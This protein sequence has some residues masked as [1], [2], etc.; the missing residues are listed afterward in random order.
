MTDKKL[1]CSI[2]PKY[3]S[4][5]AL[6]PE[7]VDTISS[8]FFGRYSV[9]PYKV[10]NASGEKYVIIIKHKNS[11]VVPLGATLLSPS[12]GIFLKVIMRHRVFGFN[13]GR[14]REKL[15]YEKVDNSLC[16]ALPKYLGSCERVKGQSVSLAMIKFPQ[17]REVGFDDLY[18]IIDLITDFHAKY[19]G[20]RE[21][22]REMGLNYYMP[23]DYRQ[24]RGTLG[25]LFNYYYDENVE[26]YGKEFVKV[27][28]DFI[29]HIDEEYAK[30]M[31]YQTLTHNDLTPRNIS[32]DKGIIIYDWELACFQNPEHDL[33]EL[34]FTTVDDNCTSEQIQKVINYFRRQLENKTEKEIS[35]EEFTKRMHFNALEYVVNRLAIYRSYSKKNYSS[36][37][38]RCERNARKV[39]EACL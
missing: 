8:K 1:I 5:Q 16:G 36:L 3:K 38:K 27:I 34:L 13:S 26:I 19:Y 33:V 30:V 18:K 23:K 24:S 2:F 22:I 6:S 9:V 28:S 25:A 20:K 31:E 15:F 14:K 29:E 37:A 32:I 4:I 12:F 35:D 39:L 17:G 21:T 10:I 7:K 11:L